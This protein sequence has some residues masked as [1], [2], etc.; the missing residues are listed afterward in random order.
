MLN[1]RSLQS[2][3]FFKVSSL[4]VGVFG[5][6]IH[7]EARLVGCSPGLIL[8]WHQLVPPPVVPTTPMSPALLT[9]MMTKQPI[10]FFTFRSKQSSHKLSSQI[11]LLAIVWDDGSKPLKL[12]R[13]HSAV[14]TS[15]DMSCDGEWWG[16]RLKMTVI[17]RIVWGRPI[18]RLPKVPLHA[19][20]L[21]MGGN[22]EASQTAAG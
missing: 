22:V 19:N 2:L 20:L 8:M 4:Q 16:A 15:W 12:C 17:R 3:T 18:M 5:W 13:L 6:S 10:W 7:A 21:S 9:K 1:R 14:T 11:N